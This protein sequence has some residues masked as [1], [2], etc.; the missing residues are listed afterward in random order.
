M[1][2][3]I[4]DYFFEVIINDKS[5]KYWCVRIFLSGG[6]GRLG[7]KSIELNHMLFSKPRVGVHDIFVCHHFVLFVSYG[8]GYR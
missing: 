5:I 4:K 1:S 3:V 7:Q 2:S 6:W 8:Y